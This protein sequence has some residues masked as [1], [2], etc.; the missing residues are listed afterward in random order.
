MR[1]MIIKFALVCFLLSLA[2]QAQCGDNIQLKFISAAY[3]DSKAVGLKNPQGV[4]CSGKTLYVADSGN[5]RLV[6]Y[7][8]KDQVAS[9]ELEIPLD[10]IYPIKV[11]VNLQGDIFVLDGKERRI[12]KLGPDGTKKGYVDITGAPDNS[13]VEIRSFRIDKQ[14]RLHLLDIYGERVMII[15]GGGKYLSEVAFPENFSFFSDLEVDF[16]GDLLLLDSV[17]GKVFLS[18]KAT[19]PFVILAEGMKE[20]MNFATAIAADSSGTIYLVDQNGSGIV[21]LGQDGSYL[22]RRLSMGWG[23]AYVYY[24]SDLCLDEEDNFVIADRNNSRVQVFSVIRK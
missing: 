9:A 2:Q 20:Y 13:K 19:K 4:A 6:K 21:L 10:Q 12:L 18:E 11:Q 5:R 22:G 3:S 15:D 16:K 14:D 7:G 8:L 24:P 23:N 17:Q 1:G